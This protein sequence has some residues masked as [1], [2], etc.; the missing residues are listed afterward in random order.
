LE[1]AAGLETI[2]RGGMGYAIDA[3]MHESGN[4]VFVASVERDLCGYVEDELVWRERG[5]CRTRAGEE[6]R[7]G[8]SPPPLAFCIAADTKR[9]RRPPKPSNATVGA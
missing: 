8:A 9:V 5:V 4:L 6:H 3:A 2:Y 7:A 1:G